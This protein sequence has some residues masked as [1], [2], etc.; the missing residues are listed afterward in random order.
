MNKN[1]LELFDE[2]FNESSENDNVMEEA[3]EL[4]LTESEFYSTLNRFK[5]QMFESIELIE[6]MEQGRIV[7]ETTQDE[8]DMYTEQ[9]IFESYCDGPYYEKVNVAN[10]EE[11]KRIAKQIRD[12]FLSRTFKK[13]DTSGGWIKGDK[14]N[15]DT[16]TKNK[17]IRFT[18]SI[19][20]FVKG[21][22]RIPNI[23]MWL[24][25]ALASFFNVWV[26]DPKI[27]SKFNNSRLKLYAWQTICYVYGKGMKLSDVKKKLNDM[28]KDELGDKYEIELVKMKFIWASIRGKKELTEDEKDS[29]SKIFNNYLL[30]VNEKGTPISNKEEEIKVEGDAAVKVV[31]ALK[32]TEEI[33]PKSE[34]SIKAGLKKLIDKIKS[35]FSKK[36]ESSDDKKDE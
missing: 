14:I 27:I 8:Q 32:A 36:D 11:I 28:Y 6:M 26:L 7:S 20:S 18:V 1:D 4:V 16:V 29:D 23:I 15:G 13:S 2:V 10:K 33:E 21:W 24:V 19:T 22:G 35:K 3:Q 12:K 30:I 5:Q 9:M 17:L 25:P 34:S 31:S